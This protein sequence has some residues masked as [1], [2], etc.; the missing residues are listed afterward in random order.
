MADVWNRKRGSFFLLFFFNWIYLYISEYFI[1]CKP[2]EREGSVVPS[3]GENIGEN[4]YLLN[5]CLFFM[6]WSIFKKINNNH[7]IM[8]NILN[9]FLKIYNSKIYWIYCQYIYIYIFN[10]FNIL[11]LLSIFQM[12]AL[13][14]ILKIPL[15]QH[16]RDTRNTDPECCKRSTSNSA[17]FKIIP[18]RREINTIPISQTY[19]PDDSSMAF[20]E[21]MTPRTYTKQSRDDSM[22]FYMV[23]S[24]Q[25]LK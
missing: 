8:K 22:M 23:H 14:N 15:L 21:P 13:V 18:F 24:S 6:S 4:V 9:I 20:I 1:Q 3:A 11:K 10:I 2:M 12:S 19:F 17:T 25:S 16:H 7:Q 5:V